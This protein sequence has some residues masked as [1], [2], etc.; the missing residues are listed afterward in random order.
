MD[1]ATYEVKYGVR[2][3]A[4]PNLT[5]PFDCTRLDRRLTFE[6]WEGFVAVEESPLL[7][8]LYFDR[9]DNGLRGKVQPGTRVLEVELSRKE[10][11]IEKS[12]NE[13]DTT[14]P[15]S[16]PS[17]GQSSHP[18]Q[19]SQ[20]LAT[21]HG[22]QPD[23]NI[24]YGIVNSHEGMPLHEG[25]NIPK[26]PHIGTPFDPVDR[27]NQED[28]AISRCNTQGSTIGDD[29][30]TSGTPLDDTPAS[31]IQGD[32]HAGTMAGINNIPSFESSPYVI[33]KAD[34]GPVNGDPL[35][36]RP[37]VPR[38]LPTRTRIDEHEAPPQGSNLGFQASTP[39]NPGLTF[40]KNPT[41]ATHSHYQRPSVVDADDYDF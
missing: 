6:G 40:P 7:W 4:Q 23:S 35:L 2:A 21:E 41:Q 17:A 18:S 34:N 16:I 8:A 39:R 27:P 22:A 24:P 20:T 13:A 33:P 10:K 15:H 38:S 37:L 31:S 19:P 28:D 26:G 32:E 25:T 1:Q 36:P 29:T 5:G 30:F 12:T 9:D 11:P 14:E 3:D